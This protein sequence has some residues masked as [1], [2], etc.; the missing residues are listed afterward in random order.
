M[1]AQEHFTMISLPPAHLQAP[2]A[3]AS[4]RSMYAGTPFAK[5]GGIENWVNFSGKEGHP[6]IQPST[7]A[8]DL[9]IGRQDNLPL[10]QPLHFIFLYRFLHIFVGLLW[11][12]KEAKEAGTGRWRTQE[13]ETVV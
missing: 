13:G 5:P 10:H 7:W 12:E 9:K 1:N 8:G 2:L 3:A 6:N 4:K 11:E